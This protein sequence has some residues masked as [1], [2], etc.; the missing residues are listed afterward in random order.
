MKLIKQIGIVFAV[1]WVSRILSGLLPFAFP[2]SIIGM[3]LVLVLL[4][5]GILR[6]GHIREKSSF[7]LSNMAFFL[8]PA[9]VSV[10]N[11]V[12]LIGRNILA[13]AVICVVSTIITFGATALAVK[14]TLALTGKF[15]GAAK[16]AQ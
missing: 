1:C 12:E 2:A 14:A 3:I 7:L 15:S 4:L 13:L 10:I 8:V 6:V 9:G 16:D 11:H 5:T